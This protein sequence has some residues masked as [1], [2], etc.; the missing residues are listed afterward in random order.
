[1]ERDMAKKTEEV[2]DA[3]VVD[4]RMATVQ[5]SST[6]SPMVLIERALQDGSGASLDQLERLYD[7]QV[8]H[9]ANEARKAY[10][11][12]VAE[13]KRNNIR[14][15]KRTNVNFSTSKGVT[16]YNHASLGDCVDQIIDALSN[17]GLSHYWS[18]DQTENNNVGVT[19]VLTHVLGHSE[20]VRMQAPPD[21]SGGKNSIQAVSSTNS[22]LQRYTVLSILGLATHDDDGRGSTGGDVPVLSDG[23]LA[24]LEAAIL[25]VGADV[26]KLIAYING[27]LKLNITALEKLPSANFDFVCQAVEAKRTT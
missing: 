3:V 12:A 1:M 15:L 7:L 9:E 18:P 8:K 22:Y 25:D 13:F 10:H 27:V 11:V 16:D 4:T 20:S 26:P 6:F 23:Q 14:I 5:Q 19:C 21:T 24:D 2:V 17:V